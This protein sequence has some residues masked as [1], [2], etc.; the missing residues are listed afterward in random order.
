MDIYP[1]KEG[2]VTISVERF[3][4]LE[5]KEQ[6]LED[7]KILFY[8]TYSYGRGFTYNGKE[9]AIKEVVNESNKLIDEEHT[10]RLE[11]QTKIQDTKK[12]KPSLLDRIRWD[13]KNTPLADV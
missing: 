11:Y 8:T 7:N 4:E 2:T 3:K 12:R 5:E 9:E 6:A 1:G 10:R 13:F